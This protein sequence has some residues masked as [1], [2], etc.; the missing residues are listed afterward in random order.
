MGK[1][2]SISKG[3]LE[4]CVGGQWGSVCDDHFSEAAASVACFQLG[5]Y[6]SGENFGIVCALQ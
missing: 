6:R 5:F 2:S 4:A 1:R 3:R